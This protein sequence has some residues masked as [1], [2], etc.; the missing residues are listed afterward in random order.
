MATIPEYTNKD[1]T[2]QP[3]EHGV[4]A[5]AAA[6]RRIGPFYHQ[7]GAEIAGSIEAASHVALDFLGRREINHVATIPAAR[8][9]P[10]P[11]ATSA[12]V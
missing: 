11:T 12:R 1:V 8:A 7:A 5:H 2:L 9:N 10:A 4:E 3:S 6:G